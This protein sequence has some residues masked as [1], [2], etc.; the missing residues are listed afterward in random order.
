M[1]HGLPHTSALRLA[2]FACPF[3]A[4]LQQAGPHNSETNIFR[5]SKSNG[6]GSLQPIDWWISCL[7]SGLNPSPEANKSNL[8]RLHDEATVPTYYLDQFCPFQNV[9]QA[10][11]SI[12]IKTISDLKLRSVSHLQW[13]RPPSLSSTSSSASS[14]LW[15]GTFFCKAG[16]GGSQPWSNSPFGGRRMVNPPFPVLEIP[17]PIY[18]QFFCIQLVA[19][20]EKHHRYTPNACLSLRHP[21]PRVTSISTSPS[22]SGLKCLNTRSS[23]I[24]L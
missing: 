12:T 11:S 22:F 14:A 1:Q 9:E 18:H 23:R 10:N 20:V 17:P 4:N 21:H 7:P 2:H 8:E 16:F 6:K 19:G 15:L 3:S 13:A 24:F 5:W